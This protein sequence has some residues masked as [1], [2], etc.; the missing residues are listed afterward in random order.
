MTNLQQMSRPVLKFVVTVRIM[1]KV[2]IKK[3]FCNYL[4]YFYF[5]VLIVL[6]FLEIVKQI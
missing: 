6:E 3:L 4:F 1:I 5:I 2:M